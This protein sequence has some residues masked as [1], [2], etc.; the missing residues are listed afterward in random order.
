MSN[1]NYYF[2]L[3]FKKKNLFDFN[4]HVTP[5]LIPASA[6][7]LGNT[8]QSVYNQKSERVMLLLFLIK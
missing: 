7:E 5:S 6:T 1:L 2:A 4:A 3:L 8:Q